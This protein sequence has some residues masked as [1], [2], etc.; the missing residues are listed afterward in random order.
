MYAERAVYDSLL[1]ADDAQWRSP[2]QAGG[3]RACAASGNT[4]GSAPM[5]W[6]VLYLRPRSEKKVA[7]LCEAHELAYYLPLRQ[8]TKIYQRRKVTVQK[9]MFPGYCFVSF[10]PDDR[11]HLLQTNHVI[12]ILVPPSEAVLEYQLDQIRQAL[13]IDPALGAVEALREGRRVRIRGG[14]FAGIEGVVSSTRNAGKVRLNVE[15]IG[16]AVAMDIDPDFIEL[17][18]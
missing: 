14:V 2:M 4:L 3:R 8:E 13:A 10:E 12:S 5:S 17:V 9:P 6:H 16:Q 7:S 11:A 15:L 18:D 1:F